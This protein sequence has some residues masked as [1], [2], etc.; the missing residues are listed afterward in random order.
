MESLV[1]ASSCS[2]SPRLPVLSASAARLR[3]LPGA[4]P[5]PASSAAGAARS[6]ARR[7]RLLVA[8]AAAAA[9]RGSRNVFEGLRAKGFASVSS[10]TGNENVSTGTGTL[11]PMPPPSSYFGSPVFWIGVGV[12]LSVAFTTVSS[13]VK[14]YAMQQAFKSMMTQSPSNSFGS[15]SPFPFAMPPQAA[16]TAPSSY[17]YSQPKRDTSPQVATV[18]V[19]ATE[20]E[21]SGTPKEADVAETP[22]PSKKFAFVD[23]SPEELQ[24]KNLQSSLETVDVK[25][26]STD[27]E[28]KEDTEQKVPTNGAVFKPNEDAARGPTESSNSGPMLSVETIEKM[29]EDP[30]VQKMVYPYL[31]EEMRNPDSFKWMLQNPMYRQQLQDML[32]N[33]GGSSPDQW[34]NRMLDHLKN[35][36]LSSPEVR[37]QFAQV[38]MTPEEVVSKIMANPEVAVAFQNPKIQT[39]IMD[40]SQNPLNIVKY[41]NDKE[42]MDVFMKI[43]QIFPQING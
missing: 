22:K 23:V 38:G 36:D 37:Q 32:N 8:V 19:L 30:A 14:R 26:D 7:P 27:S 5:L 3:G 13:M 24:Q 41:Q 34:D 11:P 17:P 1:L 15:N 21:A 42:V 12:A 2:A 29:M 20:V 25:R 35:F 18:D 4:A 33:M 28:S 6:G 40:C 9:P 10:S 39:A 16:P 43:S 31:P